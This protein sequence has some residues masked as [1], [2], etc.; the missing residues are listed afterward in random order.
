MWVDRPRAWLVRFAA[1]RYR[2]VLAACL[3]TVL[4][5]AGL[6]GLI[7]L[8]RWRGQRALHGDTSV[9]VSQAGQELL[10]SLTSRRGT[11]TFIRDTLNRDPDLTPASLEALGASA[12]EHTRHLLGAGLIRSGQSPAWWEAPTPLKRAQRAQLEQAIVQRSRLSG[13]WRVPSTLVVPLDADRPI[14][15]MLEPLR[16]GSLRRSAVIGAFDLNPMLEDFF[17]SRIVPHQPVQLLDGETIIYRSADWRPATSERRPMVVASGLAVDAAR[18]TIQMQPGSTSLAQTLSWF[19]VLLI[20][21]SVVA[22]LGVISLVWILAA[23][24]W[25]LQRIVNRRTAALRRTMERLRQLATTDE[26]TGLHNRRFFFDR[27]AWEYDRAK[28]Y[29]RP[30]ACLMI[31]VDGFKIVNDRLGH[32]AGDH[33]LQEVARE[34]RAALRQSDIL[35]R[36]GGDEFIIALPETTA[37]QAEA[38]ADKLRQTRIRVADPT[39]RRV[40]PVRLSV[41]ISQLDTEDT[42]QDIIQAADLSLY[43]AKRQTKGASSRLRDAAPTESPV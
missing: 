18:W 36:I 31:D 5:S 8:T 37:E 6:L 10:R 43:S 11:L 21:L 13:V 19:T 29:R 33:V 25:I 39:G 26:L 27:W 40:P 4:I 7:G 3:L 42:A 30:L 9:L 23:R 41:G 17:T 14:L 2:G 20:S 12:V 32:Q 24:T 22:G 35:A 16:A 34:L 38:V 15:V 1:R 28:R